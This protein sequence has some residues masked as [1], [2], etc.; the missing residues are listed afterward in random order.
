VRLGIAIVQDY[1]YGKISVPQMN[2]LWIIFISMF[3]SH[4]CTTFDELLLQLV[5][6]LHH[7][8]PVCGTAG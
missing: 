1:L 7:A 4:H 5:D 6:I 8:R 2:K 3:F